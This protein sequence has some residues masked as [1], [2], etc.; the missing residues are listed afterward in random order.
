MPEARIPLTDEALS[1][2]RA[3]GLQP[4][5]SMVIKNVKSVGRTPIKYPVALKLLSR[6]AS[7]KSDVGGVVINI[8]SRKA[9]LASIAEMEK[10][11]KRLKPRPVI[12]GFLVQEM[13]PLGIEC[14]VG[15]RRDQAFGPIVIVGLGG[16]FIEIFKDT[17]IA[18]A[19]VTK[20]EAADMLKELKAY[21]LL[22]GVRGKG[23]ADIKALIEVICRVST[24]LTKCPEICEMDLNPVIVHPDGQGVSIV[25]ARV[26]F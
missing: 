12:D 26:F 25:D 20:K 11:L 4:V 19:P 18:L 24:L 8:V 15:G 5:K 16:I 7:H 23:K 6:D 9:L 3:A 1:I 14:F 10:A 17:A 2:C 22:Q 21:P 13:A